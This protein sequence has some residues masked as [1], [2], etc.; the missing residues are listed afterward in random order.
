MPSAG[1]HSERLRPV[2]RLQLAIAV[3]R[4]R[5]LPGMPCNSEKVAM[6]LPRRTFLHLATGAAALPAASR[7][8]WA[9]SYPT[10]PVRIIAPTAPGGAPDILARLIGPWFSERLGQQFVVENRP[11]SGNN[12]G[13]EVVVRAP[14]DGYTLLMVS[15]SNAINATLYDKLNFVFLRDIAAVA[16]IISPP[17]VMVVNPSVPAKTVPEFTAYA[18][19]NPGKISFGSPGIGT[20]GHVAGELFKMMAGVE[21]IHVPYRG[22]GAVVSDLLGGQVQVLFGST[23]LTVEQ[24]MAGKLRALAVTSATRWEGLPDIPTVGDF[25]PGYEA[26]SLFGL[27][28]PKKTPAEIVDK[29]NRET[30]A[31]LGDPKLKTRLVELGGTLLAGSP[32]DFSKLIADDTEKWGKV[33]R[34]A[35]IKS[36]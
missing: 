31:A 4:I 19:A 21:M 29:L 1:E 35:N 16:G 2:L 6:K 32:A 11:G 26:S 23:S 17:F 10:R 36:D 28:A 8:A 12:I 5:M 34:A 22:G 27:G 3:N 15:S 30:N 33:I 20:P 25:V 7:I 9:Q 14:P 24:V 18:K 13:T